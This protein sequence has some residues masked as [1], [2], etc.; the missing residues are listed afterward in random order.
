MI[1]TSIPSLRRSGSKSFS[2]RGHAI[3]GKTDAKLTDFSS[4]HPTLTLTPSKVCHAPKN[5]RPAM[6][7]PDD[8]STL[9]PAQERQ[10]FTVWIASLVLFLV[11]T[12]GGSLAFLWAAKSSQDLQ[13]QQ[14]MDAA[15]PDPGVTAAAESSTADATQVQVGFYV[16]RIPELSVREAHWTAVFDVWFR[17]RGDA[18]RPADGIVVMEG[19]V[20]SNEKLAEFHEGDSHYERYRIVAKIT[21]PF[22]AAQVPL[23]SHL[24]TLA[25]ENGEHVREKLLFVPDVEN[26]SVS[27]RTSVPGYRLARWQ[28]LEK[29]HSY[30]TTRGDPRLPPGTK[31]T[32]S[33]FRMGLL[34]ER[35][36]W[37][38]YFKL[39]QALHI[40]VAI[41]FLAFFIKPTDLDPRFGLG[42]GALFAAVANSYVVNSLI[43]D[44]GEFSLADVVNCM[45]IFTILVTLVESTI[46][47]Y[48]YDRCGEPALSRRLDRT[49][50]W[51]LIVG[52]ALVNAA[53][54]W[55][56][57]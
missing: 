51:I 16:D 21:K 4:G 36:G 19:T 31:S 55:A 47:L 38:L 11:V 26:C 6:T 48:V 53:L 50:F 1:G 5:R 52:F 46:S 43:P 44:T 17:W 28:V 20:E 12:G 9:S 57:R 2:L 14:L 42:V 34:I 8:P 54:L 18:L 33:Q 35:V 40:A 30:K 29:P 10:W 56:S 32:F 39:F 22:P 45:G 3:V 27:S 49:S 23:D 24:L 7:T 15:A 37:G 41:S 13:N 25:I